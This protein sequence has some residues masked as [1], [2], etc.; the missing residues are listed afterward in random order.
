SGICAIHCKTGVCAAG[1]KT[2]CTEAIRVK[3]LKSCHTAAFGPCKTAVQGG[4][5]PVV[6]SCGDA[7]GACGT[8]GHDK[9]HCFLSEPV[10]GEKADERERW[11]VKLPMKTK[12]DGYPYYKR[13]DRP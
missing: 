2:G 1:K 7:L 3:N 4:T 13:K 12:G 9:S 11:H 6:K 10:R 8:A 5:L